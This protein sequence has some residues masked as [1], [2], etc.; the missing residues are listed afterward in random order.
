[1]E[2][3]EVEMKKLSKNDVLGAIHAFRF[4]PVVRVSSRE[5]ALCAANGI[6][7]AKFPLIEIT[8]TVPGAL[9]IISELTLRSRGSMII[10]A[11][12]VLDA[13]T[14]R[15]AVDAGAA[16]IVSPSYDDGLIGA[17]RDRDTLCIAGALTPTEIVN[18]WRAGADMVK[19][20]PCGLLG[21]PR[22]IRALKG[23][24]PQIPLMPSSGVDR[25]TAAE[26]LAAGS[27]AVAV[28]E[29]IFAKSALAEN[30][31]AAI[32]ANIATF[33]DICRPH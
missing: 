27:A 12:T 30:D 14:C 20:F 21:G 32:A 13:D 28:G 2:K 29:P 5:Q 24:F 16:F 22:Y 18:A 8:M 1:M 10:G 33:V 9:E 6:A 4:V 25:S 26:Y 23:P 3:V 7:A 31:S 17:A 15:A 11:G 19:V